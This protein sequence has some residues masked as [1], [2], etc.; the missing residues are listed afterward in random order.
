MTKHHFREKE[1]GWKTGAWI[2]GI[3][4]ALSFL[5]LIIVGWMKFT[6]GAWVIIMLVPIMVF[7]LMRLNKAYEAESVELKEDARAAA[8]AP[9]LRRHAAVV[10]V[11]D[12]DVAAA[13]AM[14]YARTLHA[15]D[16]RAVHFDLDGWKT[17]Q[18]IAQWAELGLSRFPLDIIECPE[19]GRAH[20]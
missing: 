15:D 2:N 6:Q 3:G 1:D 16:L 13:R 7:G 17:E 10:L 5:V 20:V 19:I 12:L 9:V 11:D 14:Q 4:A 8:E 18:L